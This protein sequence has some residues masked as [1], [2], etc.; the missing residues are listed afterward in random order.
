[1]TTDPKIPPQTQNTMPGRESEMDPAPDWHPRFPGVGKMKGKVALVT[2]GDSGIGRAV[3]A[4]FAREGARIAIAYREETGDA[5]DA[6]RIVEDEGS[7]CLLLEGDLGDRAHADDVVKRVVDHYGQLDTL[8]INH[9]QQYLDAPLDARLTDDMLDDMLRSN[10][11]SY[12][13]VMRA[14]LPHLKEGAS[15]VITTS[16]NAFQGNDSLIGYS[17]TRGA[18]LAFMR[19]MASALTPKGIR[20]NGV[21]PGPIWTPFI[22]GTMPADMVEDFGSSTPMG[23]C[24]QPWEVATSYLF[25]AG[26]DGS[27]ISGQTLHPNGGMIVGA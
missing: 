1:M 24:G 15:V 21:A 20:V 2:G 4:L 7:E 16:V 9:A 12:V 23:R 6:K 10:V 13:Y 14:A 27:Y 11:T 5:E 8:V 22:P 3:A 18:S 26:P 19:S 17:T 25:L